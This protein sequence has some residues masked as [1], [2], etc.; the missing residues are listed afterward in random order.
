MRY[1]DKYS[2]HQEALE[3]NR[4]YLKSVYS[5]NLLSPT[6]SPAEGKRSYN[7]FRRY[8]E[9]WLPLL[10]DEQSDHNA[11]RCCYCMKRLNDDVSVEHIIPKSSSGEEG[12]RQY[13]YYSSMAP[14]IRDHI[15]MADDFVQKIFSTI[16][17]IDSEDKMP[18]TT[19]LSNLVV[20]CNGKGSFGM[21]GCCCNNSRHEDTIMPIMLMENVNTDVKY[22]ANGIM[23]ITCND[24]TLNKII[25]ELNADTLQEIRSIWYHLSRTDIDMSQV[26]DMNVIERIE[27]FKTAY[28]TTTFA[29]LKEEIKR[30]TSFREKD[31]SDIYWNLLLSYD[32]FYYKYKQI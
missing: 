5:R 18:H 25:K 15:M 27:L 28:S 23:T 17:D 26:R 2:K 12:G 4:R 20:S 11:S 14:A 30:Y 32:W 16:N 3:K 24:G 8:K 29:T 13:A 1:I 31:N 10:L 22:D 21:D 9:Q 7:S 19:G 6:P